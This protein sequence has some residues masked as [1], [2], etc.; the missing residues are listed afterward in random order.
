[1]DTGLCTLKAVGVFPI[2]SRERFEMYI[3]FPAGK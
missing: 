2:T 3:I 1:M